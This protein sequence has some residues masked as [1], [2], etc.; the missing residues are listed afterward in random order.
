[1]FTL[2]S[3]HCRAAVVT[4][5]KQPQQWN[6]LLWAVHGCRAMQSLAKCTRVS[7]PS[8]IAE[9]PL[10]LLQVWQLQ[11]N[12]LKLAAEREYPHPLKCGTFGASSL[13]Q[14][15]LATGNFEGKLQIFDLERLAVPTF[16]TQAHAGII[17]QIDGAGGK[18]IQG[19]SADPGGSSVCMPL[20]EDLAG[21]CVAAPTFRGAP[22]IRPVVQAAI[23]AVRLCQACTHIR[24]CL[25]LT[26]V[27]QCRAASEASGGSQAPMGTAS[28][29]RINRHCKREKAPLSHAALGRAT[30]SCQLSAAASSDSGE[31]CLR[32]GCSLCDL[33]DSR[34]QLQLTHKYCNSQSLWV[35]QLNAS[36]AVFPVT[37]LL[38]AKCPM[39]AW[40]LCNSIPQGL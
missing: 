22:S 20:W 34:R 23:Q 5:S 35:T 28:N 27:S 29:I 4:T 11:G 8:A 39:S 31:A 12:E 24:C 18:V 7:I 19:G 14:R 32:Q 38:S 1:M 10:V 3:R 16:S 21:V 37:S 30:L 15:H 33:L 13:S 25:P 2:T 17:N 9:R 40:G 6:S 36:R 26:R